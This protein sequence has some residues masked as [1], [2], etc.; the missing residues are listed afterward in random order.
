MREGHSKS[1]N[2]AW[3][4]AG[5]WGEGWVGVLVGWD[6]GETESNVNAGNLDLRLDPCF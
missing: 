4:M 5:G 3:G 6:G 1:T 2:S